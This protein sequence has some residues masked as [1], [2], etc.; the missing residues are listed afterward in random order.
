MGIRLIKKKTEGSVDTGEFQE[1]LDRLAN[2]YSG[3]VQFKYD[4]D[5][6][7][8]IVTKGGMTLGSVRA[9]GA[10]HTVI[11]GTLSLAEKEA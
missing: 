10:L 9:E 11:W 3:N 6:N 8:V 2:L 7:A 4:A 1:I 5:Q